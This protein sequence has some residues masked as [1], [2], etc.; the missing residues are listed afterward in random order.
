MGKKQVC[1][2]FTLRLSLSRFN[3]QSSNEDTVRVNYK[4]FDQLVVW[5]MW[6][7]SAQR[8]ISAAMSQY[9][10]RLRS[11]AQLYTGMDS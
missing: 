4:T 7:T 2:K 10:D 3:P 6:L 8:S 9:I 11:S 1:K 5:S